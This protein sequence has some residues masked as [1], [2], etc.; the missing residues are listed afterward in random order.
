[1]R[2]KEK[3]AII[4]GAARGIG[5]ET[6][7]L[8]CKEGATVVIWDLLEVGEETAA[9]FRSQGY[10]CDFM[11]VSTT[12]V[13]AIDVATE[14][15]VKKYGKIDILVNNAGITRDKTLVK[16]SNAEWQ[17]VIDVNLTG[18]FNCTHAVV[19]HMIANNYGRILCTSSVVG[20]HG[21][22]G[23]TNY[24]ASKAGVIAMVR[25]WSRE[26]AKHNITA[27]AVAPGFIS[28]DMTAL[29]P[30]DVLQQIIK[31]IP[32]RRMGE[33]RDISNAFLY[34]ASEEASYV[35][36]QVLGVNGAYAI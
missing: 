30:E 26:L 8:F 27:N 29:M 15:V 21:N 33:A 34:L 7:E 32:A 12:D 16:M 35:N 18:V 20:I 4:T 31:S 1:M 23:Q 6:A 2:L 28:T 10:K 11:K 3:V 24:A 17:Q 14:N 5:K 25:T 19:P 9:N 22:F 13:V 36:G